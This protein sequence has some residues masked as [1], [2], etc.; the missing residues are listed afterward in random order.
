MSK[1]SRMF[2][3]GVAVGV[4]A[5]YAYTNSMRPVVKPGT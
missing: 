3:L 2:V 1:S 4:V 5:H